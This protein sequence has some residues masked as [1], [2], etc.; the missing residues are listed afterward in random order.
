MSDELFVVTEDC[1]KTRQSEKEH[2]CTIYTLL[3]LVL[4]FYTF[5]SN[6]IID[7]RY[8]IRSIDYTIR[9]SLSVIY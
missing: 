1:S 9:G 6:K 7:I 4:C 8:L 5:R 2:V 3:T